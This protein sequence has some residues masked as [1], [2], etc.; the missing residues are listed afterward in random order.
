MALR[1]CLNHLNTLFFGFTFRNFS[2]E[3]LAT[4]Q[5]SILKMRVRLTKSR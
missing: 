3:I 2:E 4:K 1:K 5:C